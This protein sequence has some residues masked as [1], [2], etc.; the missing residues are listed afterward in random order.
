M[1]EKRTFKKP[2]IKNGIKSL[3]G[4]IRVD[5][6]EN[7][8]YYMILFFS[9][10]CSDIIFTIS[11]L[12]DMAFYILQY[13]TTPKIPWSQDTNI[14]NVIFRTIVIYLRTIT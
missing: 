4:L 6:R 9:K 14:Y 10:P 2:E 11:H 12:A 13:T 5:I 1:S 3:S 8:I 7:H